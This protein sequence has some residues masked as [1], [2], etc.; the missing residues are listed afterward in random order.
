MPILG[1]ISFFGTYQAG[2]QGYIAVTSS[3]KSKPLVRRISLPSGDAVQENNAMVEEQERLQKIARKFGQD[4]KVKTASDGYSYIAYTH[5]SQINTQPAFEKSIRKL[6]AYAKSLGYQIMR[7]DFDRTVEMSNSQRNKKG[8]K[9]AAGGTSAHNYGVGGDLILLDPNGKCVSF[10]STNAMV[11]KI[12]QY[13]QINCGLEWGGEW[14]PKNES[15][16][17]ELRDWELTYK[18]KDKMWTYSKYKAAKVRG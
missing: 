9:V 13:A 6:E 11:K 10:A 8:K 18:T 5:S 3:I 14:D 15:Q 4:V 7:S 16:H 12:V 17:W 2:K 1:N